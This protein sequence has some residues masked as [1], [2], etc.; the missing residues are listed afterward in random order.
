MNIIVKQLYIKFHTNRRLSIEAL[1]EHKRKLLVEVD[2]RENSPHVVRDALYWAME[3]K[4]E[5]A[6]FGDFA[7]LLLNEAIELFKDELQYHTSFEVAEES[8]E[9]IRNCFLNK[10]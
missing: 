6:H 4:T 5:E 3:Q 1:T 10:P 8:C 7:E 9:K 2:G